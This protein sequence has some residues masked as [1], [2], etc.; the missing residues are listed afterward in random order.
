M[1][2]PQDWGVGAGLGMMAFNLASLPELA[3]LAIA[4]GVGFPGVARNVYLEHREAQ[5][6]IEGGAVSIRR[7]LSRTDNGKRVV[8]GEPKTRETRRT[9]RLTPRALDALKTHRK[10][11]LEE[12]MELAGLHPPWGAG[13]HC[14]GRGV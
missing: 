8:L 5:R 1:T 6:G 12:I 13:S 2:R 10:R 14:S 9:V 11:Q 3:S 4:G 7:T